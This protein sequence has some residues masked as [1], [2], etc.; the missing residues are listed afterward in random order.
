[1]PSLRR[2]AAAYFAVQGLAVSAWWTLLACAPTA[3]TAFLPNGNHVSALLAFA[4]PDA[5]LL[6]GGSLVVAALA[7]RAD[8]WAVPVAFLVAGAMGYATLDV[9]AW[10]A[11]AGGGWLSFVMMAPAA[12]LST[13]FA[14]TLASEH[15]PV[16][17]A[18]RPAPR[19]WNV[20][21]TI[22]QI[23]VFWSFFLALVPSFL[24]YVE[25]AIG[26]PAFAFAG[27][28]ALATVLFVALSVL[29]LTCGVVLARLGDGT[30]L[31][32][33]GTRRLVIAGPYAYVRNPMAIAGLGQAACVGLGT[34]S[35]G[36]LAYVALGGAIWNWIV[37]PLEEADLARTFGESFVRYRAAVRCWIPRASPYAQPLS[38]RTVAERGSG[39]G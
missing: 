3:R 26:L 35:L 5:L 29:G 9:L 21:K 25:R 6:I 16:F 20:A 18:A 37:R 31:P 15:L 34:G 24:L 27:Q 11:L 38:I 12:L 2:L 13:V 36:V 30:P 7:A 28:R 1:M 10:S 4:L 39:R 32:L 33:D 19:S 17:R 8:R 23:A 22:G 14:L